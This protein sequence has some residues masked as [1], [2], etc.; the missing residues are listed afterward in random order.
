LIHNDAANESINENED[1]ED[2][3]QGN[4]QGTKPAEEQDPNMEFKEDTHHYIANYPGDR[5]R[6]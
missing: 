5:P 1:K 6:S 4:E 2:N 3:E